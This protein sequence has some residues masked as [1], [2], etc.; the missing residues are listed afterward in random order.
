M[1][2]ETQIRDMEQ[3]IA[4]VAEV[5]RLN[6]RL[7]TELMKSTPPPTDLERVRGFLRSAHDLMKHGELGTAEELLGEAEQALGAVRQWLA[8]GD[9]GISPFILRTSL[10]KAPPDRDL[11]R[12]LVHYFLTKQP[13]AE[14]DRDKLDYLLTAYLTA[15]SPEEV[16]ACMARPRLVRAAI[17][18]L[19][20]GAIPR[21]FSASA[22]VML[23]EMES[24][25]SRIGD[26][27][28][29]DQM[30]HARMVERVRALKTNLGEDFYHP[31]MLTTVVRFNA[32][33][34][35]HFEK[36]FHLQ[37]STVCRDTRRHL[38]EAWELVRGVEAV[39][40]ELA[41]PETERV[42]RGAAPEQVAGQTADVRVGRPLERL[43]ERPPIDRLLR[44]AEDPQKE[45]ELR[46]IVTR[47]AR[48]VEK[49]TPAQAQAE[50]VILPLREAEL[51]LA[52]WEREA[53][54]PAATGSAPESARIIQYALGVTAWLQE[55]FARYRQ[56]R[57]DRYL[58]KTHF[59]L[60]SYAVVRALDLLKAIRGL[61]RRGAPEP[62]AAWFGALLQ[63]ALR[64]ATT[65][66]HVA[67]V[68]E[69][70]AS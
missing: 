43:E 4:E 57:D 5:A 14:N 24:L 32:T 23:H 28:D 70:P 12:V 49:L 26:F 69:E 15:G 55:E 33:F 45:Y 30:V 1:F 38:E 51:E 53:F 50:K 59:D 20:A 52:T 65:L 34:R 54:D 29:F 62:E 17:E 27:T 2:S 8:V 63:T 7:L 25:I 60:L 16:R 36:L 22:E 42:G 68:F 61:V 47:I 9:L 21:P 40:E 35:R 18:E 37:L 67:P 58:W 19:F 41:L 31:Q 46:G 39:Y 66:N 64:L 13:H 48:F 6:E 56:T 10:E 44:R 11:Q 3:A